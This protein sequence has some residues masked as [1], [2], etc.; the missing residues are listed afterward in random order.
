VKV[1]GVASAADRRMTGTAVTHGGIM[2]AKATAARHL[3]Q[4]VSHIPPR[5]LLHP[6]IL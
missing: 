5:S 4:R 1:Y 3:G 6:V 2:I